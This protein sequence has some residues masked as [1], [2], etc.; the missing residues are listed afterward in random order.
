MIQLRL[1]IVSA[2]PSTHRKQTKAHTMTH[3]S[4]ETIECPALPLQRVHH[5][6]RRNSLALRMFGIG[7]RIT[8]DTFKESLK[9]A[10]GF[11]VDH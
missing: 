5:I 3:L 4:T 1:S 2:V 9:D 8:N 10:A 7:N 11:F 6:Q